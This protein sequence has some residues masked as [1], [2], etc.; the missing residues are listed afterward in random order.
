MDGSE[1]WSI[2]ESSTQPVARMR[3]HNPTLTAPDILA[4]RIDSWHRLGATRG[5]CPQ[6]TAWGTT[7]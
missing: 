5:S 2:V 3:R 4:A 7:S 1:F 6:P